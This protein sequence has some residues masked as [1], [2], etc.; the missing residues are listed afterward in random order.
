LRARGAGRSAIK[1]A[2]MQLGAMN[3]GLFL[4]AQVDAPVKLAAFAYAFEHLEV[5]AYE[6]LKRVAARVEDDDTISVVDEILAQERAA[7]ARLHGL[8]DHALEASLEQAGV[9]A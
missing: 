1:D 6:L 7:A 3:L 9:K 8:F 5:A 4:G 2:A